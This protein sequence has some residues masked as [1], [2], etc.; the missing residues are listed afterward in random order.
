VAA[1]PD[2][3]YVV[4]GFD[5]HAMDEDILATSDGTTFRTVAQLPIPVRYAATTFADGAIW[6]IGGQLGTSESTKTGGQS[7][8]VQRVDP[9]SGNATIVAHL[10]TTL[11]HASAFTLGD[12]VFVAGG[13]AGTTPSATI[14]HID[15]AAMTVAQVGTL[16]DA[17]SDSAVA[18]DGDTAWLIGGETTSAARPLDTV[19]RVQR[20][21]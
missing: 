12:Q 11:G 18:V 3:A 9:V 10:P 2:V 20:E 15:T 1:T 4:G 6:V 17:R 16:P 19:V 13:Q 14:T 7:D 21:T 5:G 8:A